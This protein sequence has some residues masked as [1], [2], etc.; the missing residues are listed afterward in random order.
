[1]LKSLSNNRKTGIYFPLLLSLML[2][3]LSTSCGFKTKTETISLGERPI[4]V[5]AVLPVVDKTASPATALR[6]RD[7]V[8]NFLYFKGYPRIRAAEVDRVI[9]ASRI[10]GASEPERARLLAALGA[11]ALLVITLVKAQTSSKL[12]YS[13]VDLEI[14][15]ALFASGIP[16]ALWQTRQ[17]KA[18]TFLA[19]S[20]EGKTRALHWH[21]EP[22]LEELIDRSLAPLPDGPLLTVNK[23]T[24]E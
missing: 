13:T 3:A 4:K 22:L 19:F 15:L 1:M 10:Q 11:D 7:K 16:E 9:A 18:S 20:E 14:S 5:I 23:K 8:I 21:L 2:A 24:K 6:L 12:L 17:E